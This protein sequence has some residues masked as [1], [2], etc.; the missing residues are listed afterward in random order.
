MPDAE[1]DIENYKGIL[2]GSKF[3]KNKTEAF[4]LGFDQFQKTLNDFEKRII[5]ISNK[6]YVIILLI[7]SG[8][9]VTHLPNRKVVPF[10]HMVH[11]DSD[12]I[13]TCTNIEGRCK[14][15]GIRKNIR[16]IA[17]FDCCRNV[18]KI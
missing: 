1:K 6:M 17:F 5:E 15:L 18:L 2:E 10:I 4:D 11:T 12:S 14:S 13:E 8:H 16:V 9:G 3:S 7:Y